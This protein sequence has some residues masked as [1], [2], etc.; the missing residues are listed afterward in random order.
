MP[1]ENRA[2]VPQCGTGYQP[3]NFKKR[4]KVSA[5]CGARFEAFNPSF[6]KVLGIIPGGGIGEAGGKPG[7]N[8]FE[9]QMAA[10]ARYKVRP[11]TSK[12]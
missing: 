4:K 6:F 9:I 10:K 5:Q 2:N 8:F 11:L 1:V 12:L 7:I 3:I